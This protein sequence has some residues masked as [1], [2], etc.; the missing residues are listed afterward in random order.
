MQTPFND[1]TTDADL[2]ARVAAG[3]IDA[4]GELY[5]RHIRTLFQIAF[6]ITRNQVEAENVIHDVF[7]LLHERT[8][9]PSSHPG[10][11]GAWLAA[12]VQRLGAARTRATLPK[13]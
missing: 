5:D 9:R 8:T 11:V 12:T 7:V 10:G 6:R 13:N 1:A 2:L 3:E 4:L